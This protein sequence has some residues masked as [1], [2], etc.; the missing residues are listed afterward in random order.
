MLALKN[1]GYLVVYIEFATETDI[2]RAFEDPNAVFIFTTGHGDP[3]GIIRTTNREHVEP[4]EIQIP[5]GSRLMQVV[6]EN[7]H[8]SDQIDEWKKILPKNAE[9]TAW[10][11]KVTVKESVQFNSGGGIGD[12]QWGSLMTRVKSLPELKNES[13]EIFKVTEKEQEDV[14]IKFEEGVRRIIRE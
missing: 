3:P 6:L 12:A 4:H 9:L 14:T 10:K 11:G 5:K 7:C 1:K 2:I 8:I 13:G